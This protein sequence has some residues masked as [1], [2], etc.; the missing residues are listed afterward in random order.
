MGLT[1][2]QIALYHIEGD[3]CT[4]TTSLYICKNSRQKKL[5]SFRDSTT[6]VKITTCK[7]MFSRPCHCEEVYETIRP[8]GPLDTHRLPRLRLAMTKTETFENTAFYS[9]KTYTLLYNEETAGSAVSSLSL[10]IFVF[11]KHA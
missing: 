4:Q 8:S 10:A 9:K 3:N 2:Y 5:S 11:I 7:K 6:Q 1:Y